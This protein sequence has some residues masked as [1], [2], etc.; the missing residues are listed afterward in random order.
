MRISTLLLGATLATACGKS[1]DQR[2][3]GSATPTPTTTAPPPAEVASPPPKDSYKGKNRLVNLLVGKDGKTQP[4]DVWVRRGFK[5]SP[6]KLAENVGFGTASA[7]FGV[8][9]HMS[10]VFLPVGAKPDDKELSGVGYGKPDEVVTDIL[11]TDRG[12]PTV[13]TLYDASKEMT[14][15]P[16]SPAAGMGLVVVFAMPLMEFKTELTEKFGGSSF[17]VGDGTGACRPQ[18]DPKMKGL[19]LGGTSTY[20]LDLPPGKAKVSLHRWPGQGADACKTSVF[21]FEV[22]AVADKA[23]WVIVYTPDAGKTLATLALPIGG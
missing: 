10:P 8:P 5:W 2:H 4:G 7:W 18:R 13:V 19:S 23:Q 16:K 14:Q 11:M 3:A 22:D 6:V 9:E 1:D 15:A 20:E 21:D 12:A 17:E